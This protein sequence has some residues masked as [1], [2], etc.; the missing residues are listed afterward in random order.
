MKAKAENPLFSLGV[1]FPIGDNLGLSSSPACHQDTFYFGPKD[2]KA[3]GPGSDQSF[4][5][6]FR[7]EPESSTFPLAF[8]PR[9]KTFQRLA[10][11]S[12]DLNRSFCRN[13][14]RITQM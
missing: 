2:S 9:L 3:P 14:H 11:G 13:A 7:P 8:K 6:S 10:P 12:L 4:R 5:M 1:H